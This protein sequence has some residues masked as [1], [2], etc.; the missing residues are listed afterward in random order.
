MLNTGQ[1]ANREFSII[2]PVYN[3]APYLRE[4]L[5][6]VLAQTFTAWEAI[7]VDDG[8]TDGSGR[9]LDEYA[10]KDNRLGVF[11]QANS[12]ASAARNRG[13]DCARG[14]WIL[15]LDGDDVLHPDTLSRLSD[16][17]SRFEEIDAV[18]FGLKRFNECGNFALADVLERECNLFDVSETFAGTP[19]YNFT[20]VAYRRDVLG[21]VRFEGLTVGEDTLFL[22]RFFDRAG[23]LGVIPDVL[24]GYRL[25]VGSAMESS[26][27]KSKVLD[28]MKSIMGIM[29][30]YSK[31]KKHVPVS[32]W[33]MQCNAVLEL[34]P[35][36]WRM[37]PVNERREAR[38][39]WQKCIAI[40][41]AEIC[42][43][44]PV[45]DRLRMHLVRLL[46][47]LS[48]PLLCQFPHWLKL[49]GFHR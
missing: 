12:G 40:V 2:I 21:N 27:S 34:I 9:I 35:Y 11:H 17:I 5:D 43:V 1:I 4:C 33:R 39:E 29:D 48:I 15:F 32:Y 38:R 16:V 42:K 46:P 10:A 19:T 13:L 36:E 45:R 6:S 44:I 28:K 14:S 7:C 25:R 49:K 24:Y 18:Q 8:S 23:R 22:A 47:W 3:V 41:V 26:L 30:A 31:S 37:L 20:C